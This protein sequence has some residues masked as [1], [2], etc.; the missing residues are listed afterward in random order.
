[1]VIADGCRP[2]AT[3]ELESMYKEFSGVY[4]IAKARF[5]MTYVTKYTK[6]ECIMNIYRDGK[7]VIRVDEDSA[8][9]MYQVATERLK[10]YV[11]L[12]GKDHA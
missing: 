11:S 3:G 1:M 4:Q 10:S 9:R 5:G 2:N 8:D 12:N 6:D 7:L